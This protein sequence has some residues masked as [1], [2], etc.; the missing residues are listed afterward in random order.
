MKLLVI[1]FLLAGGPTAH[2]VTCLKVLIPPPFSL[3]TSRLELPLLTE[4]DINAIHEINSIPE[5]YEL[6]RQE[7]YESTLTHLQN[8]GQNDGH[9]V[10]ILFGI[11]FEGKL[12]GRV[13]IFG[14]PFNKGQASLGYS[15]R[16]E[17]WGKGIAL[18]A[19]QRVLDFLET[20]SPVHFALISASVAIKNTRS[21]RVLEKA[22]FH[23]T[24]TWERSGDMF[25]EKEF[26]P[27]TLLATPFSLHTSRLEM[28]LLTA[29]DT[30]EV[31]KLQSTPEI[32]EVDGAPPPIEE[33]RAHLAKSGQLVRGA[34]AWFYFGLYFENR[35]IGSVSLLQHDHN[36]ASI[37]YAILPEFWRRGFATEA[38]NELFR[39]LQNESPV[40]FLKLEA[41]VEKTND[42][43]IGLLEKL[44]FSKDL[45]QP[46]DDFYF[47]KKL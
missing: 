10:R 27:I 46:Q 17:Y 22:G 43:S 26:K 36:R 13:V 40:H 14:N 12:I 28:K 8:N 33:M 23:H 9:F 31:F 30:E 2:A 20:D 34:H 44:G 11:R 19:V 16:P 21:I 15:L 41:A 5:V 45:R 29:D 39:F 4:N 32:V 47:E 35:L 3:H 42:K 37:G 1:L 38:L 18:E 7:S 6:D 25:F 24:E